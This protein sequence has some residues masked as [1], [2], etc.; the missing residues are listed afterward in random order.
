MIHKFGYLYLLLALCLSGCIAES[1]RE[2]DSDKDGISDNKDCSPDNK[3]LW[4]LKKFQA[5]DKD[6]DG[7]F[8]SENGEVCSGADLPTGYSATTPNSSELDCNDN[9]PSIWQPME[10][11]SLDKDLDGKYSLEAGSICSGDK[12]PTNYLP[13]KVSLPSKLDCNDNDDTIYRNITIYQDIDG[14]GIGAGNGALT[15][16]GN[17]YLEGNVSIYGYDPEPNNSAISNFD[18]P[19]ST[20]STL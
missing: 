6:I 10:Y 8:I 16:M 11:Q 1:K 2:K 4:A 17:S 9:E 14:D 15:C 18:L 12:L 5:V 3:K 13:E 19:T 20:F 7:K